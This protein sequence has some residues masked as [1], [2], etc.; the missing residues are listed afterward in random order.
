[1]RRGLLTRH[2]ARL[3][4]SV[5][6]WEDGAALAVCTAPADASGSMVLV[7]WAPCGAPGSRSDPIPN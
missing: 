5:L 3:S 6:L 1:M 2:W 7:P 4:P